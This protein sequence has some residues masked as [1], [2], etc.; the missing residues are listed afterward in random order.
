MAFVGLSAESFNAYSSDKWSSNVHNLARMR[1]KET[2]LGLSDRAQEGLEEELRGLMRATSDEIPNITNHKK[3]DAQW[4]YWFRDAGAREDLRSSLLKTE[5]DEHKLFDI[6]PQDKHITLALILREKE[7]WTGLRIAGGATVDRQNFAAIMGKTWEREQLLEMLRELPE[8]SVVGS[9]GALVTTS[10]VTLDALGQLDADQAWLLGHSLTAEE[11]I[12]LG[13]DL[14]DYVHR[15]LGALAPYY[16]FLAW[17]KTND[18]I[19]MGKQIQEEKAQKRRQAL[20]YSTGDKVRIVSG[21][22]A[23]KTGVVQDIDTKAQVKIQVGKM[24][25]VVNG[26]DLTPVA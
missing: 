3:V 4:V 15:W 24:S 13:V 7:L 22:F 2:L 21:V 19:N 9:E 23:G 8:G 12:E 10:D 5:L 18:H 1:V 17:G 6:A 20:G 16:R 11:A 25:L 26:A 14:A